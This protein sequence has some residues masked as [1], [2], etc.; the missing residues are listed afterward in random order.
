MIQPR[1][2]LTLLWPAYFTHTHRGV[3]S[4]TEEKYVMTGWIEFLDTQSL[5]SDMEN[6][7]DEDFFASLDRL[8]NENH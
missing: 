6:G 2:G 3:P 1:K 4:P 5:L 7:S 8:N